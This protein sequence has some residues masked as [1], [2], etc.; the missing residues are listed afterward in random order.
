M[1]IETSELRIS[2][3][4]NYLINIIDTLKN[5]SNSKIN[6]NMLSNNIDNYSLDK[7]PVVTEITRWITGEEIHRDLYSFRSRM[8]YSQDTI[9]NLQNIGFFEQ[10]E[11]M[12]RTNNRKGIMPD[13][14]N[15]QSIECLNCGTMNS[16]DGSTAEFDIQIQITYI[17]KDEENEISL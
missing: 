9:N 10:F 8:S 4:R 11:N 6:V 15:I 17:I 3:L 5:N 14:K 7:I 2:K 1:E 12:I 16:D 13:I